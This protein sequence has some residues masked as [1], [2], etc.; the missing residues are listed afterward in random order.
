MLLYF[1]VKPSP[2]NFLCQKIIIPLRFVGKLN[3]RQVTHNSFAIPRILLYIAFL[4]VFMSITP[5]PSIELT[6]LKR[7][8]LQDTKKTSNDR[9]YRPVFKNYTDMSTLTP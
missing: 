2:R 5:F 8:A 1:I 9:K 7:G 4:S 3:T 6:I